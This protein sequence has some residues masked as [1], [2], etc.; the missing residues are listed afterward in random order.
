[1]DTATL[2][3][4]GAGGT[5]EV[6]LSRRDLGNPHRPRNG[7]I[8]TVRLSDARM[9]I[10]PPGTAQ[11]DNGGPV[12][13]AWAAYNKASLDE[14]NGILGLVRDQVMEHCSGTWPAEWAPSLY[15]GCTMCRCTPGL[16]G[17]QQLTIGG[18]VIDLHITDE[19]RA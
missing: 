11:S 15:A 10:Q 5:I 17:D 1:M 19:R 16:V 18:H 8:A 12:D 6:F 3:I 2:S 14:M 13:R 4:C 9:T 7:T